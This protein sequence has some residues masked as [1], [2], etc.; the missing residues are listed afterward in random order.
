MCPLACAPLACAP[1]HSLALAQPQAQLHVLWLHLLH[2]LTQ[3]LAVLR[4]RACTHK[5]PFA[6]MH[7]GVRL[8]HRRKAAPRCPASMRTHP[9]ARMRASLPASHASA[10]DKRAPRAH[11]RAR[12][13]AAP[14]LPTCTPFRCD[15]MPHVRWWRSVM[16]SMGSSRL[17]HC[18]HVR[19]CVCACACAQ[20]AYARVHVRVHVRACRG[21]WRARASPNGLR[22]GLC[23]G[24]CLC[25]QRKLGHPHPSTYRGHHILLQCVDLCVQLRK[26]RAHARHHVL[27]LHLVVQRQRRVLRSAR[28]PSG[29][30]AL[31]G[32]WAS[33]RVCM[34][35]RKRVPHVGCTCDARVH[36]AGRGCC[37]GR[38]CGA[39]VL[40]AR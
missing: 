16:R 5:H 39:H 24:P 10:H 3:R 35:V 23:A 32:A 12:A 15:T 17:D 22:P 36:A 11:T 28:G 8:L 30:C 37:G 26:Q 6:H 31:A 40:V 7:K 4:T 9:H 14:C 34:S 13:R 33:A 21:R 38:V 29:W 20:C 25:T 2:R 18:A 19:A 1:S 27:R